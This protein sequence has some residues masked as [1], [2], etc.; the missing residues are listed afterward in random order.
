[1]HL[2]DEQLHEYLDQAFA[3]ET[4]AEAVKHLA[5]CV[6]CTTRLSALQAL[7]VTIESLPEAALSRD[8]AGPVTQTLRQA[9]DD[10]LG[11]RVALPRWIRLTAG[12]QAALAV[13]ALALAAPILNE[14]VSPFIADYQP[15]SLT[16]FLVQIQTQWALWVGS[17]SEFTLPAIPSLSL[18]LS[19]LALTLAAITAFLLWVVGN[20]LLLR[21][22]TKSSR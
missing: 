14:Y 15:P 2:S 21:R 22:M 7:F 9:Q 18:D 8:L 13:I 4:R 11:G 1:M 6:D 20:G 5:A 10:A 12:L 17:V 16:E 19:S 3:P